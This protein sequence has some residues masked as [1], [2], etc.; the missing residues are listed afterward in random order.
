M[1]LEEMAV[2]VN[3]SKKEQMIFDYVLR[4]REEAAV[5]TGAELAEAAG[6]GDTTVIRLARTLGFDSLKSFRRFLQEEA[7]SV[8]QALSRSE[9]PYEKIKNADCL[10]VEEIPDAVRRQHASRAA[11]DQ[12]ANG[13]DKY[14]RIAGMLIGAE[15]K[16]I[17]GFRNTAGLADYFTAVL[18]HVLENVR[19][20]N[21]R[22]GF[23][24]EAID[25]GERDVLILFSLPRYS[26]HALTV[27]EMARRAGCPVIAF[28]DSVS[29]PVAKGAGITVVNQVDSFS[30]ANSI[31]S[32]A[33]SMEIIVTLVGK[34]S[35]EKGRRRLEKLDEYMTKTGLY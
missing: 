10:A 21:R 26:G 15:K 30:F 14:L 23:E 2:T 17:A 29:S 7:L 31:S 1:K 20:V 8:K 34:L 24:D 32:L 33:L 9:L 16:Y 27:A 12:V 18:S 4:H 11:C 19:N 22:D 28:T 13:D 3:L 6:V 5:M 35:G 25:M